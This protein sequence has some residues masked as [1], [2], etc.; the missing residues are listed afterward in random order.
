MSA[1]ACLRPELASTTSFTVTELPHL[2]K[3]DQ[4]ESAVDL[5]VVLKQALA[6]AL[7]ASAWNRY[8][9]PSAYLSARAALAQALSLPPECVALTVGGDQVIQAAFLLAGGPGRRARWFEP[10]YPYIPLAARVTGTLADPIVL[11]PDVDHLDPATVVR[12]FRPDLVVLV[13]PNN[14]TGG[15]V[16]D[17]ALAAA[18]ADDRRLVLLDEAYAD[19]A[20]APSR[21][22]LATTLP[23]LV[24]G[25]SLSKSLCAGVRLG[26]AVAHPHIVATIERIYTAPYHL[27][28]F[29]LLLA[30]RYQEILPL[31]Q[32]AAAS[33]RVERARVHAALLALGLQPRPSQGNF[34]YFSVPAPAAQVHTR[35]AQAGIRVRNVS[36]LPGAGSALRVTIGTPAEN[37]AFLARIAESV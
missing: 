28:T 37:D 13:S 19:F 27:N 24:V 34:I 17:A 31:V 26:F 3:L 11:G 5:P 4:N 23:N 20:D 18:L 6:D 33:V 9:Q 36:G 10:T 35:L 32:V 30:S 15:V 29:Q 2:A 1:L 21:L 22:E 8:P 25:R 16:S 12:G 14:P 7:A